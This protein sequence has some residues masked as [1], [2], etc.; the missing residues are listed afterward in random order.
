MHSIVLSQC[1]SSDKLRTQP[2]QRTACF[3]FWSSLKAKKRQKLYRL[4][5][6]ELEHVDLLHDDEHVTFQVSDLF[7]ECGAQGIC[8]TALLIKCCETY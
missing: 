3:L 7:P 5:N 4:G 1:C 6:I 2:G 8:L